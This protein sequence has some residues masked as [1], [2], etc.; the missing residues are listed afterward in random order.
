MSP[1]LFVCFVFGRWPS[2]VLRFCFQFALAGGAILLPPPLQAPFAEF[3]WGAPS[4]ANVSELFLCV[5]SLAAGPLSL[6]VSVFSFALAGGELLPPPPLQ[7]PFAELS[8]GRP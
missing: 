6:C 5:L 7:A 8:W 3:R 4:L 1:R 2:A